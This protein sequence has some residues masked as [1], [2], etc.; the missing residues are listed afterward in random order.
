[1]VQELFTPHMPVPLHFVHFI[2]LRC[3][4][5]APHASCAFPFS[6]GC[7]C[8]M[9]FSAIL[10]F[11]YHPPLPSSS[12][13]AAYFGAM[14]FLHGSVHT[15]VFVAFVLTGWLAQHFAATRWLAHHHLPQPS[16]SSTLPV[17]PLAL[18]SF[19]HLPANSRHIPLPHTSS[20]HAFLACKGMKTFFPLPY[21]WCCC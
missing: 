11:L 18:P 20:S 4:Q 15:H 1:M 7:S 13:L 14:A 12:H 9:A 5:F 6:L 8:G 3:P 21:L 2:S 17:S 19:Y 10:P 16:S